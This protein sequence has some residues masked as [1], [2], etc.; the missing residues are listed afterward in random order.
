M[1]K[2]LITKI[3][4]IDK[5][6]GKF[7][8]DI[9]QQAWIDKNIASNSWGLPERIVNK[10]PVDYD[11]EDV[12]EEISAITH[13]EDD[14]SKPILD[15]EGN[16]VGYEKMVVIDEVA[17]VKLKCQ[18]VIT[19]TDL[20]NDPDYLLEK[21]LR[22]A[23]SRIQ[24]CQF[25]MQRVAARNRLVQLT[26]QQT[27][28][29]LQEYQPIIALLQVGELALA[30]EQIAVLQPIGGIT[31]DEINLIVGICDAGIAKEGAIE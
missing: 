2:V 15:A 10:E 12:I 23:Q 4:S 11:L 19:I 22:K 31:Q 17:K 1:K 29:F 3:K 27:Q 5:Y 20:T 28:M 21:E 13:E 6:G 16:I 24:T 26:E 25:V 18:Y 9:E 7:N 30:R 8:N 14:L